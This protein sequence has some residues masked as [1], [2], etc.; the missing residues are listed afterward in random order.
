[1]NWASKTI[2]S[3]HSNREQRGLR[4]QPA[5]RFRRLLPSENL[6][7]GRYKH[8]LPA[9]SGFELSCDAGLGVERGV[10]DRGAFQRNRRHTDAAH[11][12][13]FN[14]GVQI[15]PG[16]QTYVW[17][18]RPPEFLIAG[19]KRARV[20]EV[21][22]Q[23]AIPSTRAQADE[24]G[25]ARREIGLEEQI[26]LGADAQIVRVRRKRLQHVVIV[27]HLGGVIHTAAE[28]FGA[29][30]FATAAALVAECEQ[31]AV[32]VHE[33]GA[34]EALVPVEIIDV[35]VPGRFKQAMFGRHG[36]IGGGFVSPGSV[37]LPLRGTGA[38][39]SPVGAMAVGGEM[40]VDWGTVGGSAVGG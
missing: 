13:Q 39:S 6:A 21:V 18:N 17:I 24:I 8:V 32:F 12:I 4:L 28:H 1:M 37:P 33:I 26:V 3:S 10:V 16:F 11:A 15:A 27:Q 5:T 30:S 25:E 23:I 2:P 19:D 40:G 35:R 14:A 31:R 34:F 22:G 38:R 20:G 29:E 36:A 7:E 9:Q